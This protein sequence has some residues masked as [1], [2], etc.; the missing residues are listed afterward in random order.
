MAAGG[1][2]GRLRRGLAGYLPPGRGRER[3]HPDSAGAA[4]REWHNERLVSCRPGSD[5]LAPWR[6]CGTVRQG[7]PPYRPL[8]RFRV[9]PDGVRSYYFAYPLVEILGVPMSREYV[10]PPNPLTGR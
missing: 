3:R 5:R 7:E 9:H 1:R 8:V 10:E 6:E 2:S 4:G